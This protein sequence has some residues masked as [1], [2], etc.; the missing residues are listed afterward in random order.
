MQNATAQKKLLE[1]PVQ[2]GDHL[3][4]VAGVVG[5]ELGGGDAVGDAVF[6]SPED[7]LFVEAAL[8][9]IGEG[10]PVPLGAV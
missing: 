10:W 6:Q 5:T 1:S 7:C 8:G 3:G 9:H 2:E 4:P